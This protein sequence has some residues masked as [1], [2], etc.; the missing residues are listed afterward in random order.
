[1]TRDTV[2]VVRRN[3]MGSADAA[4]RQRCSTFQLAS[5][6]ISV[7]DFTNCSQD[8]TLGVELNLIFK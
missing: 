3:F 8:H 7:L 6:N 4:I 1:M 2:P 5:Q